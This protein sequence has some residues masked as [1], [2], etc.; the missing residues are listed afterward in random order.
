MTKLAQ[1]TSSNLRAG[2]EDDLNTAQAQ[3]AIFDMVRAAN[4]A[5]DAGQLKKNDVPALLA[6]LQQFDE[7]FSVLK[8]DDGEKMKSIFDWATAEGLDKEI[9]AEL[10]DA[11]KSA[12]LSDS[13]IEKKIAEMD[14]AR[15]SRNFQ[16]SDTVRAELTAAGILIEITKDTI[17][18]RR[19]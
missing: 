6:A 16:L 15:K 17:R 8:D 9:S 3:G 2:L 4:A 1:E 10:T 14:A 12:E 19:K 5:V 13:A 18:W 11:V 7:I